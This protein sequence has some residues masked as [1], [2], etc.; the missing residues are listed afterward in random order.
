MTQKSTLAKKK[1]MID[2]TGPTVEDLGFAVKAKEIEETRTTKIS[3]TEKS[4]TENDIT[5]VGNRGIV[6]AKAN[7]APARPVIIQKTETRPSPKDASSAKT[8]RRN[9][10]LTII[11][12]YL[13]QALGDHERLE[14]K[15]V[16]V[17]REL[18]IPPNTFYRQLKKLRNTEFEIKRLIYGTEIKRMKK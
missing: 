4:N 13:N 5:E 16:D 9:L 18:D 3:I 15:L 1:R 8:V 7:P 12:N 17:Q 14:I 10:H 11:R 2:F 6:T